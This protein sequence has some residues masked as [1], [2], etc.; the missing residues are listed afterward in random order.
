MPD[1]VLDRR[2]ARVLALSRQRFSQVELERAFVGLPFKLNKWIL[3]ST[4]SR[5]RVSLIA[6]DIFSGVARVFHFIDAYSIAIFVA[7]DAQLERSSDPTRV[8]L[9]AELR[10]QIQSLRWGELLSHEERAAREWEFKAAR[11]A[12]LKRGG[13]HAKA[14][15]EFIFKLHEQ[16]KK[17]MRADIFSATPAVWA[18]DEAK[19]FVALLRRNAAIFAMLVDP[20]EPGRG[21][22]GVDHLFEQRFY[23]AIN[24]TKALELV[25]L[26]LEG[27]VA[28][29]GAA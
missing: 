28:A 25:D 13:S 3:N 29:R 15:D 17:Q 6:E 9:R 19:H 16:S 11:T 14:S 1:T 8:R 12:G 27:V 2:Q 7:C 21:L 24:L 5:H 20:E 23:H 4:V 10:K 18:R 22:L 26:L